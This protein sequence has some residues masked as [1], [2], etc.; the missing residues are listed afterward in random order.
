MSDTN[1]NETVKNLSESVYETNQMIARSAIEAQERNMRFAQSVF[2]SG[3]EILKS[4]AAATQQLMQTLSSQ[5]QNPQ[6]AM[7]AVVE[8][9]TEAQRRNVQFAQNVAEH[10]TEVFKG[11]VDATRSLMQSVVEK[12]REQQEMLMSLPYVDTYMEMF[13]APL[14]NYKQAVETAQSLTRQAM[15][16]AQRSAQQ[17]ME[18]AQ[19]F[20]RQGMDAAQS[21][22]STMNNDNQ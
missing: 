2:D 10:G 1:M 19:R 21:A 8:S 9:T 14:A 7:Q 11:H 4:H 13:R 18:A 12:T 3:I 5:P 16:V 17:G 15:E 6:A 20:T 22:E